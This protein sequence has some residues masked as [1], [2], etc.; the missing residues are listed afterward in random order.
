[1]AP[2]DCL[3]LTLD[4]VPHQVRET[5]AE[6]ALALEAERA[7]KA[8]DE[9][10]DKLKAIKE[11]DGIAGYCKLYQWFT[12]VSGLGL[13]E[14]ARRLIHPDP[15][16]KEEELAECVEN[17]VERVRRLESHGDKYKLAAI[18]KITALRMMMM[19]GRAKDHFELW[20]A[21]LEDNEDGFT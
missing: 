19:I 20:Q 15:P 4:C 14:Q 1:M 12:E 11:R 3:L 21:E 10:Y 18:F 16:R 7:D 2:R 6:A 9:A 13:T 17:W 5:L 8:E